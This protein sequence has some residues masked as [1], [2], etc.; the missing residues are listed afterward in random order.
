MKKIRKIILII[1]VSL[2]LLTGCTVSD[3]TPPNSNDS[4]IDNSQDNSS[5][6]EKEDVNLDET[7]LDNLHNYVADIANAKSL[8]IKKQSSKNGNKKLRKTANEEI[9]VLVKKED[10]IVGNDASLRE[11]G[12]VE[13]KF[14]NISTKTK[15]QDVEET[16]YVTARA[17]KKENVNIISIDTS[18]VVVQSNNKYEYRLLIGEVVHE[19]WKRSDYSTIS[20]DITSL[21]DED[22][23]KIVIESRSIDASIVIPLYS[24]FKYEIYDIENVLVK[25]YIADKDVEDNDS[26]A[27]YGFIE[28]ETYLVKYS[29]K[30]TIEE[31]EQSE[32]GAHVDKL[33]VVGD[34]TFI[35]FIPT[36]Y[37]PGIA[38]NN[39]EYLNLDVEIDSEGDFI[40][41]KTNYFDSEDRR[42]FVIDNRSGLIYSLNN[43]RIDSIHNGLFKINGSKLI[44]DVRITNENEVE[45]Y[46][47]YN[48][49][50]IN[51]FEYMKDKYGN[52][53]IVNLHVDT[54]NEA[55]NT[56]FVRLSSGTNYCFTESREVIFV[57]GPHNSIQSVLI[58]NENRQLVE[59]SKYA[60]FKVMRN[61]ARDVVFGNQY[62]GHAMVPYLV[63]NGYVYCCDFE[64]DTEFPWSYGI[65]HS[66]IVIFNLETKNVS[67]ITLYSIYV[68]T[69]FL[70]KYGVLLCYDGSGPIVAVY[71]INDITTDTSFSLN[72]A[73]GVFNDFDGY[74]ECEVIVEN[75]QIDAPD[76]DIITYGVDGNIYWELF[77]EETE[78]GCKIVPHV[79]GTYFPQNVGSIVLKPLQ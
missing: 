7:V 14:T 29:G 61:N 16:T 55:T 18:N 50:S 71:G 76:Y 35:S 6:G 27:L 19:D 5:S 75:C 69:Y 3:N 32:I 54:Y 79:E 78:D 22:K 30:G 12:T 47:L 24:E 2:F 59:I 37:A 60:T 72:S 34:F 42:S 43:V 17:D 44:Y 48:N 39:E 64:D 62:Y 38:R 77:A 67:S 70:E 10:E 49:D 57:A 58:Y 8:G 31:I 56:T 26:I 9:N 4:N 41:D 74:A 21:S 45:F 1:F 28:G 65:G 63:K 33:C 73:M 20:F 36:S 25:E 15:L 11:D 13:V 53:Y 66:T 68:D 51:V 23:T 52:C 40:Y 46:P